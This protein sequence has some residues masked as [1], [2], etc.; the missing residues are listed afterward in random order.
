MKNSAGT[1]S[2]EDEGTVAAEDNDNITDWCLNEFQTR[3]SDLEI[4]KDDIWEY[5]YGVMHAPDWRGRYQA[6]LQKGLPR[7]P[8]AENF[9]AFRRAG[10]E[11]M[12]LHIGFESCQEHPDVACEVSE[13]LDSVE[14]EVYSLKKLK[15]GKTDTKETDYTVLE[16]NDDCKLVGIPLEAQDYKISGRSPLE[17][18][19]D[20]LRHK[21][22]TNTGI[23]DDPNLWHVWAEDPFELVRHLRRLV[24]VSTETARIVASLP[25][26]LPAGSIEGD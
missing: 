10:R 21:Y 3:Y 26:A 18:A 20:S 1:L 13:K 6:H 24:W 25:P 11:L 4:T 15:W 16:I 23:D 7:I 19:V 8:F 17:W 2:F 14:G 12:D 22:D 9:E 5:L